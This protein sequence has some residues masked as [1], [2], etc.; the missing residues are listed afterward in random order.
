M[1]AHDVFMCANHRAHDMGYQK[2]FLGVPGHQVSFIGHGIG[3]E[4][5]EP[6]F[7]ARGREEI[8]LPGMVF[9]LEPK[10]VFKD[11]FCAGIE[12]VFL[13]T[14]DGLRLISKIPVSVFVV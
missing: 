2:S 4:L 13:L 12:S 8:L 3:Y 5:V 6:P 7:I 11:Q 14:H 10:F 1:T 9:A